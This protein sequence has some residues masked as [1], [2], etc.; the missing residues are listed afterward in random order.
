MPQPPGT[1]PPPSRPR[2]QAREAQ[3][4]AAL[5][6]GDEEAFRMLVTT[7]HAT[8]K[9]VA[10]AYV[11]TDAIAEDVVQET[12]LAAI[13][14]LDRFEER[15]S[16]KTWLFHILAN[17]ARTRAVREARSV[18]FTALAGGQD[19]LA[20]DPDR[21]N[22]EDDAWPGHLAAPPRPGEDPE[23]RLQRSRRASC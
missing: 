6:A 15:A 23:R 16:L 22:G 4:V 19:D 17:R 10:R 21:F 3:L 8:L 12:W 1:A 13:A 5:R 11:R 18:P 9:R 7:W 20:V 14:G 2:A